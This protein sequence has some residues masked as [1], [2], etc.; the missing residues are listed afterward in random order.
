MLTMT[1]M[2]LS[3]IAVVSR[4]SCFKENPFPKLSFKLNFMAYI[5]LMP[6]KE[7]LGNSKLTV[8]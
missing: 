4:D 2:T 3:S 5:F 8:D 6:K 7:K 1:T